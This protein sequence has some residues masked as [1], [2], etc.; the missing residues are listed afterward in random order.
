LPGGSAIINQ[1]VLYIAERLVTSPDLLKPCHLGFAYA[2]HVPGA[3]T[4]Q[5][6]RPDSFD[7]LGIGWEQLFRA[8]P[9]LSQA[10]CLVL[11]ACYSHTIKVDERL[12]AQLVA[13]VSGESRF[14]PNDTH[15]SRPTHRSRP[16]KRQATATVS[17]RKSDIYQA[18]SSIAANI[19]RGNLFS[20]SSQS[21]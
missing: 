7:P 17:G 2:A 6:L 3:A 10:A 4:R 11:E 21:I 9:N 16:Q 13:N 19:D 5:S 20:V 8:A 14:R 18:F 12:S 15:A 1:R